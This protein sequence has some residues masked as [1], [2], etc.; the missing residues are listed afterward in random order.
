[1]MIILLLILAM[2][3]RQN[4]FIN[5]FPFSLTEKQATIDEN[6]QHNELLK[7]QNKIKALELQSSRAIDGK[8]LESQARYRFG[9]VKKGERYYQ[10]NE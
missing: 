5:D 2:L 8:I 6:T 7:Q 1:M 4:L 10:V 9:L 3:I